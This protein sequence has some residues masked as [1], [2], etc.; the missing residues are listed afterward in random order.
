MLMNGY[1]IQADV[2]NQET[3]IL[4]LATSKMNRQDF[5]EWLQDHV[6]QL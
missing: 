3:L 4:T 5:L 2:D 1:E 6:V